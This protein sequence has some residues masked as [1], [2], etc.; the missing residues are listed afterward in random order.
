MIKELTK[1][2]CAFLFI[3][4]LKYK[5]IYSIFLYNHNNMDDNWKNTY[6]NKYQILFHLTVN[7][8]QWIIYAFEWENTKEGATF[9]SKIDLEWKDFYL[10]NIY[11][12]YV[13]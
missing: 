7:P 9:W 4:W 11:K 10:N 3:K 13:K 1:E 8:F 12:M 5:K 6:F 2:D